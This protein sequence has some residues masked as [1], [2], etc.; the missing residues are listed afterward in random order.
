MCPDYSRGKIPLKAA[1]EDNP[2][3]DRIEEA[4]APADLIQNAAP[5]P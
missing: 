2:L 1:G 5:T 3:V 4:A